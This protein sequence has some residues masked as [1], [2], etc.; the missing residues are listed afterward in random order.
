MMSSYKRGVD[1]VTSKR[2]TGRSFKG[3]WHRKNLKGN[4]DLGH[5]TKQRN[6][7]AREMRLG[8]IAST[9]GTQQFDSN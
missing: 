6:I 1:Q 4:Y 5:K 7:L 3:L 9:I 2:I 8:H